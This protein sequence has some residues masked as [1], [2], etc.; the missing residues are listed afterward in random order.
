MCSLK[1]ALNR[2]WHSDEKRGGE[3][4]RR[5][6]YIFIYRQE[7]SRPTTPLQTKECKFPYSEMSEAHRSQEPAPGNIDR[8]YLLLNQSGRVK[9]LSSSML[10]NSCQMNDKKQ[11]Q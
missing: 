10:I 2:L 6:R 9:R 3:K 7:I 5:D 1:H 8:F 11:E 4:G